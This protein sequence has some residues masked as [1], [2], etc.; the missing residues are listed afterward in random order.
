MLTETHLKVLNILPDAN[1]WEDCIINHYD[2]K[3]RDLEDVIGD[4]FIWMKV[5]KNNSKP[6]YKYCCIV[7]DR[8]IMWKILIR[9]FSEIYEINVKD[10]LDGLVKWFRHHLLTYGE[11]NMMNIYWGRYDWLQE[12]DIEELLSIDWDVLLDE[13]AREL[14]SN[15]PSVTPE[16]KKEFLEK[17]KCRQPN[18]QEQ[19]T[20]HSEVSQT[21]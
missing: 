14:L 16:I 7:P 2:L 3:T 19:S 10:F 4:M 5:V 20:S 6:A 18:S 8:G 17:I 1:Y 9:L 13:L 11:D 15:F 21:C 12:L